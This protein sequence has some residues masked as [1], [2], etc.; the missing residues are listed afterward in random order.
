M[1][2]QVLGDAVGVGLHAG[3]ALVPS[4]G[5]NLAM[6]L[7]EL[8]GVDQAQG[9]VDVAAQRQVIDMRRLHHA[10]L[11][12]HEG[13]AQRHAAGQQDAVGLGDVLGQ[14]GHHGELHVAQAALLHR[15]VLPRQMGEVGIDADGDD[16]G[17]A[18]GEG[19]DAMVVGQD[20]RR[21]DEG[22][23]QRIEEHDAV[24][25]GEIR[26][27]VERPVDLVVGHDC[28]RGKVGGGLGDQRGR[29]LNRVGHYGGSLRGIGWE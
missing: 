16:L 27:Q 22:E 1:L 23:V 29:V 3:L 28:G 4:G 25:T 6:L 7:G 8:Q 26:L 21:A 19:L 15:G 13:A 20:L 14:V 18:L 12:D 9:L 24:G 11:V 10:V 2:G 5:A 17:V